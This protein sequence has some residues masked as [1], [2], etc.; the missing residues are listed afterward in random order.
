MDT[1]GKRVRA[2]RQECGYTMKQLHELTGLSTGNISDIENDRN[3]PSVA[4][5]VPLGAALKRSLD[6]L[7][8]GEDPA[9][10]TSEKRPVCDGVELTQ[11]EADVIAMFRLLDDR[12]KEDVFDFVT[13]K[14]EK[15]SGE[16]GSIYSTYIDD[17]N[18]R[19]KSGPI[20]DLEARDGTA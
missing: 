6:W 10:R 7:L 19:K 15:A 13:M 4:S 17:E 8:T 16:K 3:T 18:E 12:S 1:I 14:Y 9:S 11:A 5:L 20:G 2:A